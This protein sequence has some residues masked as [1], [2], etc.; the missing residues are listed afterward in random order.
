M[1]RNVQLEFLGSAVPYR[2]GIAYMHAQAELIRNDQT[3]PEKLLLLEH[4]ATITTTKKNGANHLLIAPEYLAN[5]NIELV[6]TD[7]GGDITFH[8]PGQLVGYPIFRLDKLTDPLCAHAYDLHGYVRKLEAA[9]IHACVS[10][11][12]ENAQALP[13]FTGVWVQT[14]DGFWK[15]LVAIGVGVKG[16]ISRHGFALNINNNYRRFL[17]FITPCGLSDKGVT[18]LF[19]ELEIRGKKLPAFDDI[20]A[21][22]LNSISTNFGYTVDATYLK[23][24]RLE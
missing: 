13:G 4:L 15:K 20:K 14:K 11:G 9:L 16:G 21:Q 8:G 6:E 22:I 18:N 23:N 1:A 2:D 17:D 5:E 24:S 19:E 7:R 10:L 3:F 12:V